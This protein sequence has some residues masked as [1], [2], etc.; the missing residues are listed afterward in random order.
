M[1]WPYPK[2]FIT[3]E[4]YYIHDIQE[5]EKARWKR[6]NTYP[7]GKMRHKTTLTKLVIALVT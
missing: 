5:K 6:E 3:S 1:D 4:C 2:T 7:N